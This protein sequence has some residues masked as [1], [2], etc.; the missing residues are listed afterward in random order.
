MVEITGELEDAVV[1]RSKAAP[2]KRISAPMCPEVARA[3][4]LGQSSARR[5]SLKERLPGT[6]IQLV[7][8]PARG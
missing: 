1:V 6:M 3:R 7:P 8:W 4:T 5:V 2:A